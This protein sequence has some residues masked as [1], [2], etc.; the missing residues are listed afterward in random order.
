MVF[1]HLPVNCVLNFL[2]YHLTDQIYE[3]N[4]CNLFPMRGRGSIKN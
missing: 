3:K 2:V 4:P 1:Q